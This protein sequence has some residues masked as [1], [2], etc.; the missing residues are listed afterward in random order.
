MVVTAVNPPREDEKAMTKEEVSLLLE[1]CMR[2]KE[3][4][5]DISS[6]LSLVRKYEN[7]LHSI[8]HALIIN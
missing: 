6:G 3:E 7:Y 5:T 4:K 1:S 8:F 2:S